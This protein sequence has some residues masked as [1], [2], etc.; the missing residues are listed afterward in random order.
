MSDEFKKINT[1]LDRRVEGAEAFARAAR[2]FD[3]SI[4]IE[5]DPHAGWITAVYETG[6]VR[7]HQVGSRQITA[8]V[9]ELYTVLG[10]YSN[11][12]KE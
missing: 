3:R 9:R 2:E 10:K 4:R 12:G 8:F 1:E 5:I 11:L 6:E 7:D